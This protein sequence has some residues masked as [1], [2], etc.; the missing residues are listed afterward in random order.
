MIGPPLRAQPQPPWKMG[1][2]CRLAPWARDSSGEILGQRP[3]PAVWEEMKRFTAGRGPDTRD[4]VWF[5]E[6]PAIFTLGL[7]GKARMC[8]MPAISRS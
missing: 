2:R 1:A 7:N 6:H 4:E 5:V 3:L 8:S